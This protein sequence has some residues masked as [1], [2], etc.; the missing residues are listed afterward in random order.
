MEKHE[1][2]EDEVSAGM[3][4][5]PALQYLVILFDGQLQFFSNTLLD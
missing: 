2:V 4:R 3:R 1:V 5:T